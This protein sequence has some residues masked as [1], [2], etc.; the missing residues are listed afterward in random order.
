MTMKRIEEEIADRIVG[1]R[2]SL[3]WTQ[4]QLAEAAGITKGHLSRIESGQRLPLPPLLMKLAKTL[5]ISVSALLPTDELSWQYVDVTDVKGIASLFHI[6]LTAVASVV[7]YRPCDH[8]PTQRHAD[9][10]VRRMGM[11]SDTG[12]KWSKDHRDLIEANKTNQI[13]YHLWRRAEFLEFTR[14]D[15]VAAE[16]A[17]DILK[18]ENTIFC[19]ISNSNFDKVASVIS[20]KIRSVHWEQIG[21]YLPEFFLVKHN[22]FTFDYAWNEERAS[23]FI[24]EAMK[25]IT[26]TYKEVTVT[27]ESMRDLPEDMKKVI[28]ARTLKAL[29]NR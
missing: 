7:L 13:H 6:S 4:Q 19:V 10:Y 3:N 26:N 17:S 5:N 2:E 24:K 18:S 9:E 28:H 8:F 29:G 15:V 11:L 16:M 14:R 22:D 27:T 21:L 12:M 20:K 1:I 25:A 23:K